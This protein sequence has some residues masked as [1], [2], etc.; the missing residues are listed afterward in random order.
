MFL[1]PSGC[2]A[3]DVRTGHDFPQLLKMSRAELDALFAASD[4]GLVPVGRAD[5]IAIVASDAECSLELA[6]L[7]NVF[8]GLR[9]I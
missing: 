4:A 3:K 5:G 2:R 7:I 6:T 1:R 8:T 9:E